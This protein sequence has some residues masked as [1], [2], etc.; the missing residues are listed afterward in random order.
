MKIK[1][2]QQKIDD[3][4]ISIKGGVECAIK[5]QILLMEKG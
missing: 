5:N 4:F 3:V 2:P 1:Y